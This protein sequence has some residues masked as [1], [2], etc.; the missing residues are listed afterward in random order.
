MIF[1]RQLLEATISATRVT[2]RMCPRSVYKFRIVLDCHALYL[3]H[4]IALDQPMETTSLQIELVYLF[5]K[6]SSL[7]NVYLFFILTSS[8]MFP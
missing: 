2:L 7:G 1:N 4:F 6:F 5:S 8:L 3:Q